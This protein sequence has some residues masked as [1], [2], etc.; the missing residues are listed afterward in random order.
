[1]KHTCLIFFI[2][3]LFFSC[4]EDDSVQETSLTKTW[5]LKEWYLKQPLDL[6]NDGVETTTFAPGCLGD[7]RIYFFDDK[8]GSLFFSSEVTYYQDRTS[9]DFMVTCST[10]TDRI[11]LN[12]SQGS[13]ENEMVIQTPNEVLVAQFEGND[14]LLTI[15]DGFEV[16]DATSFETIVLMDQ[17]LRFS[18]ED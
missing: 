3:L 7:S 11:P 15:P 14:L 18:K 5:K 1:M 8:T 13:N 9:G 10:L 12:I 17:T 2:S 4:A 6:N 16:L